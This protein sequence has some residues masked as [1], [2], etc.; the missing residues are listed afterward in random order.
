MQL[1]C[2]HLLLLLTS[3]VV[4]HFS[5]AYCNF[6]LSTDPTMYTRRVIIKL[7]ELQIMS[8][9]YYNVSFSFHDLCSSA[10]Y[11]FRLYFWRMR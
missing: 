4:Q 9:I 3:L 6:T 1:L 2:E 11:N 7:F 8:V 10:T 5:D